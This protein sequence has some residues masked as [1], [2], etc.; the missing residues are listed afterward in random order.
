[1]KGL[2]LAGGFATRL[3][4]LSCS[5][6]KLLFPI[7]GVPLIDFMIPWLMSGGV[8][9]TILAVNHLSERLRQEIGE[10]RLGSKV[11]LSVESEPLGTA[12]PIRLA[13]ERLMGN[14]PFVVANGDIVSNID[15]KKMI[16]EHHRSSAIA[17][18]ALVSVKDQRQFGSVAVEAD[19]QISKFEEKKQEGSG[20]GLVN[21]GIYVLSEEVMDYVPGTGHSSLERDVF[22]MLAAKGLVHGWQHTG[23]WYDIGRISEYLRANM[24]LLASNNRARDF[25]GDKA[26]HE[27][28]I[29]Q[30]IHV[31]REVN[32]GREIQLGPKCI[33]SDRVRIGNG[34]IV[35]DSIVFEDTMI[36]SRCALEG[37]LVGEKVVVGDGSH[38]GRGTI[39]AGQISIPEGSDLRPG[40]IVLS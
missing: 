21:A 30:P 14:G 6:P 1:M 4:P 39:I 31:G 29:M 36:G 10:E 3:R 13:Q 40:S 32:L 9:E 33:L 26:G 34:T 11:F 8:V 35:K 7:V 2:I 24:E 20:S 27:V 17:T 38:I 5:K 28:K 25:D 23:Y 19:G 16:E 22:P 12:G 18:I 15:L 37:A